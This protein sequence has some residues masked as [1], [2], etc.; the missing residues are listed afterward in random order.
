METSRSRSTVFR[1]T[2]DR[3]EQDHKPGEYIMKSMPNNLLSLVSLTCLISLVL[4]VDLFAWKPVEGR[5][6]TQWADQVD[7]ENPLP[8]YPRPQLMRAQWDNLNGLWDYTVTTR[9]TQ[10]SNDTFKP[11]GKILVPFPIQSRPVR[12][13][14]QVHRG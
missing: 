7:P 2:P 4:P 9:D 6:M 8:E 11:N 1:P 14:A 5:I 3:W 13:E 10:L 12:G